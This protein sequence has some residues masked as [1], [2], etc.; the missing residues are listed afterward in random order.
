MATAAG[1][2]RAA[3]GVLCCMLSDEPAHCRGTSW[4]VPHLLKISLCRESVFLFV[5]LM[6]VSDPL[7]FTS[8][9]EIS[10]LQ[11]INCE[12]ASKKQILKR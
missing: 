4:W 7:L 11:E 12:D 2:S 9:S 5:L 8:S 10:F 6:T 3:R 1:T